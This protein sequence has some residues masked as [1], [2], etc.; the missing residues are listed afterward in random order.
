MTSNR[1]SMAYVIGAHA[2]SPAS[3]HP[4]TQLDTAVV[5]QRQL[6]IVAVDGKP[7]IVKSVDLRSRASNEDARSREISQF[8]TEL[9]SALSEIR[10]VTAEVDLLAAIDLGAR[11]LDSEPKTMIIED[12]GLSTAGLLRFQQPGM[13]QASAR[14]VADRLERARELP[15]LSGVTVILRGFGDVASPQEP[16]GTAKRNNLID[17]WSAILTRA[18]ALVQSDRAPRRG[19]AWPDFAPRVTTVAI[20][21]PAPS[22]DPVPIP[23]SEFFQENSPVLLDRER[24]IETLRPFAEY[25]TATPGRIDLIGTTARDGDRDGQLRLSRQRA[26][27]IKALLVDPLG[28]AGSRITTDGVGSF[29]PWYIPDR[30]EDG[31]LL[32]AEAARNR[33]VRIQFQKV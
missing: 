17:I 31:S 13:L 1:G 27:A 6:T 32:P 10:P 14:E 18:G 33:T 11:S 28:V 4:G 16:L 5:D 26:D 22:L 3:A 30:A 7:W 29:G 21:R 20:E 2:N 24:A 19:E 15:N 8:K 25:A 9:G 12:S 23:A